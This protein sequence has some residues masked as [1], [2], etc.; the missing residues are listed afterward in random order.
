MTSIEDLIKQ[1]NLIEEIK[2]KPIVHTFILVAAVVLGYFATTFHESENLGFA[3]T[4]LSVI[5]SLMGLKGIIWPKKHFV[6]KLTK[7]KLIRKEY[8]FDADQI[9]SVKK[10]LSSSECK[11]CLDK[12]AQLP[13]NGATSIRVIIY[14]TRCNSYIKSQ[15][16]K[17]IPYEYVPL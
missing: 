16:Q 3:M 12:L 1:D 11:N 13:Q 14:T 17:Y 4:M 7:E 10:C 2:E 8:Y 6:Y 15:V 5:V 9:E